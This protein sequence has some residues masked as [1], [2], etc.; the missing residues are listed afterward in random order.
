LPDIEISGARATEVQGRSRASAVVDGVEL[1][2]A[3]GDATLDPAPEAF[4]SAMLPAAVLAEARLVV[5]DA[6]DPLWIRNVGRI[7][8]IWHSWWGTEPDIAKVLVADAAVSG[9][10]RQA[11]T[12]LCFSLGVDSFFSL[13]RPHRELDVLVAAEGFDVPLGDDVRMAAIEAA[14][15][16]VAAD[17]DVKAIVVRTNLRDHPSYPPLEWERTHGGAL[18]ALGQVCRGQIGA[19]AISSTKPRYAMDAWGSHW[20]TDPMWSSSRLEIV[21]VGADYRRNE[22]VATIVD[23]PLVRRHLRVCWENRTPTGNCGEC[24]KCVRTMLLISGYGSV[25]DFPTFPAD[26]P[27][28]DTVEAIPELAPFM[29][30]FYAEAVAGLRDPALASAVE[31]LLARSP[32]A[33]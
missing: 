19:L 33:D 12:G 28:R 11:R 17:R 18:A 31:R 5:E 9:Q 6:L 27:L 23:E 7:L 10:V 1:F 13:L 24:E 15:R 32:S 20:E 16:A 30:S 21:H 29:V 3:S 4:A 2:F 22:K 14:V 26:R 25:D 8:R